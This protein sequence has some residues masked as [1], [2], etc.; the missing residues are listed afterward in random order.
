MTGHSFSIAA[1]LGAD[2]ND[3]PGF[4]A[5]VA[6]LSARLARRRTWDM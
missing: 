3:K 2:I 1:R 5:H 6:R 4:V